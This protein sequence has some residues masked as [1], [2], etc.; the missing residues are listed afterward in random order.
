MNGFF[1]NGGRV[2]ALIAAGATLIAI[3]NIP[4]V[5]S[6]F[7]NAAFWALNPIQQNLWVAGANA[8][9]FFRPFAQARLLAEENRRLRDQSAGLAA[10][11]AEANLL[12]RENDMLRQGLG[13]ELNKEFEL[14]LADIVGRDLGKDILIIN[15]GGRDGIEVGMPV[16]TGQKGLA[17]K[18]AKIY[19]DFSEVQL[20]TEKNFSFDVKIG[21]QN[22]EGL[23]KGQ[24]GNCSKVDLIPKDKK[25]EIGQT[26][27]SGGLGGI[28][29]E[30]FPVGRIKEITNSD[31][32]MFQSAAI[33]TIFDAAT[34]RQV[35]VA[36]KK[37]GL[38]DMEIAADG[39]EK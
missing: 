26:I 30:G 23:A 7:K 8:S 39:N 13:L 20:L 29:P 33:D 27:F 14:R 37:C 21:D 6:G 11:E 1:F 17:G 32:E 34:A 22:I 36:F 5:N 2:A 12:R 28:F 31:V 19:D 15:K 18:I 9:D 10:K 16:I 3:A 25:L 38:G 4:A 35:F 24:G